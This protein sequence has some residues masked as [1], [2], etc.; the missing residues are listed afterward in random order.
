MA[1]AGALQ[2]AANAAELG[3]ARVSSH[4]G[5]QLVAD[6]EL[7]QVDDPAA[8]VSVRLASPEVYN[9]AGVALPSVLASLNLSVMRRDGRQFIHVTSLRPVEAEHL[10][11]YLEL[12]D[13]GQRA[14]RLVTLWLTPDP[15]PAPAPVPTPAPVSMP[16][17]VPVPVPLPVRVAAAPVHATPAAPPA[18]LP[19]AAPA[20]RPVQRAK[21]AAVVASI[22]P[23]RKPAQAAAHVDSQPAACA[24]QP[25]EA[26]ACSALGAKNA[27]LRGQ[28]DKLEEKVKG[29][30]QHM[31]VAPAGAPAKAEG[32]KA[33]AHKAEEPKAAEPKA[34]EPKAEEPKTEA[35]KAGEQKPE[36]HK[37]EQ[38][39]P[40]EALAP[41]KPLIKPAGPK[42]ISSIKP[43]VI[44]KP[45][46]TAEEGG[47]P[48][49]WIAAGIAALAAIGG[50]AAFL[51]RGRA[52]KLMHAGNA[53]GMFDKLRQRFAA[54]NR[55]PAAG[56]MPEKVAEP[57]LD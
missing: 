12:G 33:A 19:P 51:L 27:A 32:V 11:L 50:G 1:A 6:I 9:G 34:E 16:P 53:P 56:T 37:P 7:A 21:P 18:A 17:P 55:A 2:A 22:A 46:V 10:H 25:D 35:H 54:R 5:Q 38:H 30:Q 43:L 39:K 8:Q 13:K 44:H 36:A 47:A 24:P 15:N 45:K 40:E 48:W 42:P 3:E 23:V 49:G 29:L 20:P 57:S 31:G 26:Q 28:L 41:P 52:H 4:I 14:V